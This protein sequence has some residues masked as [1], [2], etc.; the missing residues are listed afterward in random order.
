MRGPSREHRLEPDPNAMWLP[1]FDTGE[2]YAEQVL[3]LWHECFLTYIY[4]FGDFCE[5]F[6]LSFVFEESVWVMTLGISVEPHVKG[7][8]DEL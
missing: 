1:G 4:L 5:E 3:V 2:R 8:V 7:N 6:F